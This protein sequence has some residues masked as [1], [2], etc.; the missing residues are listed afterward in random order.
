MQSKVSKEVQKMQEDLKESTLKNIADL[1][2][3]DDSF[4]VSPSVCAVQQKDFSY[5][6][7]KSFFL[8][9]GS[10]YLLASF[11]QY[12]FKISGLPCQTRPLL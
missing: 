3:W 10:A 5:I 7:A 1:L 8:I 12:L 9:C 4:A 2:K 6:P 11:E